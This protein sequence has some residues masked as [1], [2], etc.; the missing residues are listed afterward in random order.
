[1]IAK[2][3]SIF[4]FT[5]FLLFGPLNAVAEFQLSDSL[6]PEAQNRFCAEDES[7]EDNKKILVEEEGE[8]EEEE[9]DCD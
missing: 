5:V 8:E 9:P 7:Q 3:L 2:I 4:L 6:S 1:M